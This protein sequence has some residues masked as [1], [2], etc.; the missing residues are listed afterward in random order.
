[1]RCKNIL[2]IDDND[3]DNY[4]HS[5]LLKK[6][7]IAEHIT[8]KTCAIDAIEYLKTIENFP[9]YIFIDINMP[10]MN[11]FEFLTEYDNFISEQKDSCCIFML[12]SSN[13]KTDIE[14]A[15]N[16]PYIKKFINK[17]L[18]NEMLVSMFK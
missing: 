5:H 10:G 11:G 12:T 7:N 13:N 15:N 17:S 6:N 14:N 4:I 3:I 18:T 9:C 8:V 2:L 1:M 16:N